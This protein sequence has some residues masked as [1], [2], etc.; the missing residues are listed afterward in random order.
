[1]NQPICGT[2]RHQIKRLT[3]ELYKRFGIHK[4]V[5]DYPVGHYEKTFELV[6]ALFLHLTEGAD[7]IELGVDWGGGPMNAPFIPPHRARH[8]NIGHDGR[9]LEV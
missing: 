5:S 8:L 1:M 4:V 9:D 3:G 6:T 7:K 2:C